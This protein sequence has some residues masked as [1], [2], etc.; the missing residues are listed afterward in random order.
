M[1]IRKFFLIGLLLFSAIVSIEAKEEKTSDSERKVV[2]EAQKMVV[3]LLVPSKQLKSVEVLKSVMKIPRAQF[4]SKDLRPFAYQDITLPIGESQTISPPFIVAYM[5]E[6][7]DPKPTDK[8]LE[9]GTGSGY[10]AA[11]LSLLVKDVYT[12]EI[13]RSLGVR[14]EALLKRLK[15]E[16]V[17]CKVGDGYLGWP[18]AAPFDKIIVTCSPE[19][20]PQALVDQLKEGGK[21]LI[22][23]GNRYQQHFYLMTK[24]GGKMEKQTLIPAFF[25]PMTGEA[26]SKRVVKPDPRN[27]K[28][29]GGDFEEINEESNT[30]AGWYYTRNAGT[31]AEPDAPSGSS[32]LLCSNEK[33]RQTQIQKEKLGHGVGVTMSPTQKNQ[34]LM[35]HA[36]QAF[37]LDGNYVKKLKFSCYVRGKGL[38]TFDNSKLIPVV[39]ISFFDKERAFIGDKILLAVPTQDFDW[40]QIDRGDIL[41]PRR[42]REAAIQIGIL[43]GIGELAFDKVELG[44][45]PVH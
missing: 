42:T 11:V 29:V 8:V 19:N 6:Q 17:H 41:V 14:A 43:N 40:K 27:P 32:V 28:L 13:V 4:V 18:D 31:S 26:E 36:L 44:K 38:K 35:S 33:I 37:A 22:P 12:I 34:E 20:I 45:A 16:N 30:P 25:V 23:L 2:P 1:K 39:K 5:T 7:L 24:K 9:I 15:F 21:I 3:D 10:Q